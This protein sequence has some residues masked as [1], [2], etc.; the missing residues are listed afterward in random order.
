I[1]LF[2]AVVAGFAS[3]TL[4]ARETH[5]TA[6]SL[7]G[8]A[9]AGTARATKSVLATL[10][11][12]Q[13]TALTI[14]LSLNAPLMQSAANQYSPRLVPFYLKNAPLRRAV[15]L[16]VFSCG[17]VLSSVR[18]LG[19]VADEVVR[20]RPVVSGAFVLLLLA[21]SLLTIDLIRTLNF[22]RVE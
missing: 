2:V 6:P 14:V 9:W 22:M 20:P 18:E 17:Y 15:P 4:V 7:V 1:V 11:S 3:G 8:Q 21:F 10:F 13:I 12:L 19:L 16:F 5:E